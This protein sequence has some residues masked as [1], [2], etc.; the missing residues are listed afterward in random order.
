[1]NN[2]EKLVLKM[3]KAQQD[4]NL[5]PSNENL[6]IVEDIEDEVDDYLSFLTNCKNSSFKDVKKYLLGK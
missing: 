5:N 1:M 2:F 4:Y 3:R 6:N